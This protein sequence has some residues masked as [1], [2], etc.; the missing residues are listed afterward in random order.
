MKQSDLFNFTYIP[1][2]PG[3][4]RHSDPDTSHA[5]AES[6]DATALEAIVH[7]VIKSFGSAGCISDDVLLAMPD[8]AYGTVTP[9]YRPLIAKGLIITP[10]EKRKGVSGRSQRVMVAV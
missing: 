6:V 7:Q 1:H 3:Y 10:G 2:D 4:A 8:Y 9:R 5:A